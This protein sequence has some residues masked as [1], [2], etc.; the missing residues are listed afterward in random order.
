[1]SS[2]SIEVGDIDRIKTLLSS[3]AEAEGFVRSR[4]LAPFVP[5]EADA[6][7]SRGKGY[8]EGAPSAIA[9]ALPYGNVSEA[10]AEPPAGASARLDV[11]SRR[12]YYAEAVARMQRIGAVARERFGGRRSDYR[13][14]CN[15]PIPEKPLAEACGLGKVGRNTLVI[16]PEAG[17]LVVI[18]V[19]TLPF[20]LRGDGPLQDDPDPCEG[21]FACVSACPT[22]ALDASLGEVRKL[23]RPRCIQFYASRPGE[24]PPEIAGKWGDRLYGCSI[25]RDACP[26]NARP[27]A[28]VPTERGVLPPSFDAR[29]L[30]EASD[31]ELRALF[32]GTALGMSWLGPEAVRRNARLASSG[33]RS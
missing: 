3:W 27:I 10:D 31:D 24:I 17:S 14:Y 12:N 29:G 23:D 4:F 8:D 16:T 25:C 9:A 11:F 21:C 30:I 20:P 22:G 26:H 1:M 6:E 32:K 33:L 18:A 5:A 13:I 2:P 28:G 19:M 15:S 7:R